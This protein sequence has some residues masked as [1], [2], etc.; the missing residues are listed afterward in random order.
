MVGEVLMQCQSC[1]AIV[2][3]GVLAGV[4]SELGLM[5]VVVSEARKFRDQKNSKRKR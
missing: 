2:D 1:P 3:V 4:A 5:R